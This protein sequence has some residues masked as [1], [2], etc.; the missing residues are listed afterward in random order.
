MSANAS[1]IAPFV[2]SAVCSSEPESYALVLRLQAAE[3]L[4]ERARQS[5]PPAPPLARSPTPDPAAPA[6]QVSAIAEVQYRSA[7]ILPPASS[8]SAPAADRNPDT[9]AR[10]PDR[11]AAPTERFRPHR[12]APHNSW[13]ARRSLQS[14]SS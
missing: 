7:G 14:A 6:S 3:L 2:L 4:P 13:R 5:Y 1:G 9:A 10:W 8:P 12:S 11:T